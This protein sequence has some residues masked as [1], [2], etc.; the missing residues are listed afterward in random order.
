MFGLSSR[1]KKRFSAAVFMSA[2]LTVLLSGAFTPDYVAADTAAIDPHRAAPEQ[3][4]LKAGRDSSDRALSEKDSSEGATSPGAH[5]H[6]PARLVENRAFQVGEKLTFLIRYGFISAGSATMEVRDMVTLADGTQAYHVITT[7]RSN[8]A[9]D[10]FYKVRDEVETFLDK[11]G[12][13]SLKYAKRLREGGYKVDLLVDYLQ[14]QGI[15]RV[16]YTRYHSDTP[17]RVKKQDAFDIKVP[18][19]VLDILGAFYYVRT[20]YLKVGKPLYMS[21]HDNKKLYDLQVVVQRKERV[22]VKAGTF[23][24]VVVS[25]KLQ[26]E[27]I[28]RQK[29]EMWVW[30]TDDERKI[31]V[32]MKTK[33]IIGSITTEL[34]KVEGISNHMKGD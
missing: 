5:G 29:G 16:R 13:F 19:Y 33:I 34:T 9:F 7:A 12:I 15:A 18:E 20:Q 11:R 10:L 30:L 4:M 21:N 28:F 22:K 2:L 14:P 8:A 17:L 32:Q 24:C 23:D 6:Q 26:G 3:V 1:P 31:P 27:G 25:P